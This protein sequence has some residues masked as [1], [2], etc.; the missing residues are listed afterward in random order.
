MSSLQTVTN[1][2]DILY[3]EDLHLS[4]NCLLPATCV[5]DTLSG[6]RD[7]AALHLP[8]AVIAVETWTRMIYII[9]VAPRQQHQPKKH[10]LSVCG[11]LLA[12]PGPANVALRI[13]NPRSSGPD[14]WEETG[15]RS[16]K[17]DSLLWA[18]F[19][20]EV[21]IPIDLTFSA[22]DTMQ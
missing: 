20:T 21:F 6:M 9:Y 16:G 2:Y 8:P 7:A 15:R 11:L 10:R 1:D 4:R 14:Q 12:E 5:C 17:E 22:V 3:V 19:Y 13:P 18:H